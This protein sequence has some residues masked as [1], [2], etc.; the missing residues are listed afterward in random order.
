MKK[1]GFT[2]LFLNDF[3]LPI[4]VFGNTSVSSIVSMVSN[5]DSILAGN[6]YSEK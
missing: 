6:F 1:I 3:K 4:I 2:G 5:N